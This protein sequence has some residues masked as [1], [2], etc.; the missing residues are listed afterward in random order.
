VL[1][2]AGVYAAAGCQAKPVLSTPA[3]AVAYLEDLA[4]GDEAWS[5]ETFEVLRD[6]IVAFARRWDPQPF[7]VDEAAARDSIFGGLMASSAHL[8]AIQCRLALTVDPLLAVLAGL[9]NDGLELL[10]PTRP[11]DRLRLQRRIVGKRESKT[12]P[13]RGIV[14]IGHEIVNQRGEVVC[15]ALGRVMV[16][17][18]ST[19]L[20]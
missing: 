3:V 1:R 15:R 4:V 14:R 11:G 17:R 10:L 20:A 7:H 16:A 6:E 2:V 18:R 13:D 9:G 12:K 19:P 5:A 8:F